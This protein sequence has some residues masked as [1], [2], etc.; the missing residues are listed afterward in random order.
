MLT[1]LR[2]AYTLL[3]TGYRVLIAPWPLFGLGMLLILA[4]G[5]LVPLVQIAATARLL[6]TLAL[7]AG[8]PASPGALLAA[9]ARPLGLLLGVLLVGALVNNQ[10]VQPYLYALH[11][12]RV[13]A[14]WNE[15]VFAKALGMRLEHFEQ[16]GYYDTLMRF[17][18]QMQSGDIISNRISR[19]QRFLTRVGGGAGVLWALSQAHWALA[20]G[21]L[22]GCA[23]IFRWRLYSAGQ[24]IALEY[25]QTPLRRRQAYWQR[26]LTERAAAAEVRLF[27]LC[28]TLLGRWRALA[29]QL[30]GEVV[31]R[32]RGHERRGAGLLLAN[33]AV[34]G[35]VSAGLLLLASQGR[36][37]GGQLVALLFAVQQFLDL[38]S[39]DLDKLR[40]FFANLAYVPQ[41]LALAGDEAP[42]SAPAPAPGADMR[43]EGVSFTYPGAANPAL[44]DLTLHIRAGER[45]ALVGENGAGK[46]TLARLLLGL[47]EPTAGRILVGGVD[48][49]AIAPDA[50][51]VQGGAVFQEFMRY[52]L[53]A[54]ENVGLGNLPLLADDA[55]IA[56]AATASGAHTAIAQ[57]PQGYAT[58]LTTAFDE[59]VDL[60]GGQWQQ[61]AIARAHLRAAPLVVLD[62]PAA[63][64]DARAERAVYE[65]FLQLAAGKTVLLISHRLG[66]A[67]LA[68]RIL[69][70]E[71]GQIVEDGTHEQL[72]AAG[73]PYAAL[74]QMQAAWYA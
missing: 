22:A 73:G 33:V 47:Y 26:L 14:H 60:S 74:Y 57:L 2:A 9:V 62:E 36:I 16:P 12:E 32:R 11:A 38:L 49:R 37:S 64:L 17:F 50:W 30:L 42:S 63:A 29:T 28:E 55:A 3:A 54:R 66:S 71:G 70:L 48:L 18:G 13:M 61:L 1:R 51:R 7:V 25:A 39:L 8:A 34:F 59:G 4:V 72:L 65:Q 10:V 40:V 23:A 5:V 45:I 19:L 43:F 52:P 20:L 44:R 67:R 35:C 68:D 58:L 15:R 31:R 56:R 27:D 41:F 6:D 69:V 53:T 21:L 46:T 24:L